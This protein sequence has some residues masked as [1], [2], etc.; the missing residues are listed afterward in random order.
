MQSGQHC[1]AKWAC[2]NQTFPHGNAGGEVM[3]FNLSFV[4]RAKNQVL[5]SATE[6][7]APRAQP[8]HTH[9]HA[10]IC[11]GANFPSQHRLAVVLV[12]LCSLGAAAHADIIQNPTFT[13][14]PSGSNYVNINNT[15]CPS[16][17][18]SN[19]PGN[20]PWTAIA[21]T[22]YDGL[23]NS[24]GATFLEVATTPGVTGV[25]DVYQQVTV[26]TAGNYVLSMNAEVRNDGICTNGYVILALWNGN[27]TS[28]LSGSPLTPDNS[29][30]PALTANYQSWTRTYTLAAGS[31]TV[32]VGGISN[33]T[34]NWY[35]AAM[36]NIA[37]T[38]VP[39]PA[40]LALLGV[41]TAVLVTRRRKCPAPLR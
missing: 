35:D 4:M 38:P 34:N 2:R 5:V 3:P 41:G 39:E 27:L 11:A 36:S 13:Y 1:G 7:S 25:Q 32:Q 16:W 10:P 15:N 8:R 18:P 31:Y 23:F 28:F 22:N 40:S 24:P 37:L 33:V 19:S 17:V 26:S 29:F 9:A 6:R 12:A 20:T 21:K 30:S 14:T